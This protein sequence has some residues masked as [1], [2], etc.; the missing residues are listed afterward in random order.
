[1]SGDKPSMSTTQKVTNMK[2]QKTK[3]SA[4]KAAAEVNIGEDSSDNR[5][6]S[7][8]ELVQVS[9]LA[10]RLV[11]IETAKARLQEQITRLDDEYGRIQ[12]A[13]LPALMDAIGIKEFKLTS[14]ELITVKPI[15]AGS[16]PSENA[17]LKEK[18]P[19][20]RHELR[21]RLEQGFVYLTKNGAG[22]LIKNFVTAELGKDS[23]AL[24]KKACAALK[25]LGI[26]PHTSRGVHPGALNSWIKERIANGTDVDHD[27]FK[28]YSG[29]RAEV[30]TKK[31]SKTAGE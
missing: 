31:P 5:Q 1:M 3:P 27:L 29:T 25:S 17:V 26:E 9:A 10:T 20:K 4:A 24:A 30:K 28:I 11:Q 13:D 7:S 2:K 6:P 21:E 19:D 14:G 15:I 16:L 23:S 12:N 8:S 22:A 18:D